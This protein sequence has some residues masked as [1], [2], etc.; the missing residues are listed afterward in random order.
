MK[1]VNNQIIIALIL[2]FRGDSLMH[3][4]CIIVV[5]GCAMYWTNYVTHVE[6]RWSCGIVVHD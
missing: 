2:K 6:S 3:D 5:D 4:S 1:D